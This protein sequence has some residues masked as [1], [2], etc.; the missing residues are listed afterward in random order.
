LEKQNAERQAKETTKDK[1][2]DGPILRP[3]QGGIGPGAPLM[4]TSGI[5]GVAPPNSGNMGS[6]RFGS[7]YG[8]PF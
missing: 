8:T 5:T 7:G 1:Q 4:I 3:G 6:P 2:S